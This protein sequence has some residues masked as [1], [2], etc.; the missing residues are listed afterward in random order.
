MHGQQ[1]WMQTRIIKKKTLNTAIH[2]LPTL[3]VITSSKWCVNELTLLPTHQDHWEKTKG[4]NLT[5]IG[6]GVM[7]CIWLSRVTFVAYRLINE[8]YTPEA[9]TVMKPSYIYVKRGRTLYQ[10]SL[11]K[12]IRCL[13]KYRHNVQVCNSCMVKK[14]AWIINIIIN[15]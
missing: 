14:T 1:L 7:L 13:H 10:M 9:Q 4:I 11:H 15:K 5:V 8:L 3:P 2:E 6:F 12:D